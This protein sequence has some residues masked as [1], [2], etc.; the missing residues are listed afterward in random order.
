[1]PQPTLTH[2]AVQTSN[3]LC[4]EVIPAPS[5]HITSQWLNYDGL[6]VVK[7][8]LRRCWLGGRKSIRPVKTE[9]R[10]TG[11]VICLER[12]AIWF[13]Y[14]FSWC[15]CHPIVSCSSY[16][17]NGLPF[18]CRI[19]QVVLEKRPLNGCILVVVV[20]VVVV[21]AAAAAAALCDVTT[22]NHPSPS[23]SHVVTL[24]WPPPSL[25]VWGQLWTTPMTMHGWTSLAF[26]SSATKI[27]TTWAK[28]SHSFCV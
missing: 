4:N 9:W 10:G 5:Y 25:R 28:W 3:R 19:A 23:T 16:I 7:A 21:V 22:V 17:Q 24:V 14:M 12:G 20:V 18:W 15:H 11:V 13:A 1:V 27:V 2:S 6:W 8:L 26:L